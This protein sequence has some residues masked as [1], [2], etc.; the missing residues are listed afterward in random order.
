MLWFFCLVLIV[1]F[2][3][4]S[5]ISFDTNDTS[6]DNDWEERRYLQRDWKPQRP[7]KCK[8]IQ[9]VDDCVEHKVCCYNKLHGCWKCIDEET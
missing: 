4:A 8:Y 6:T 7:R 2:A 5:E 9:D 1:V 3:H